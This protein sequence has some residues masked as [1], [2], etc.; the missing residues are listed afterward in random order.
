[1]T[2][3]GVGTGSQV[4][5][6]LHPTK[7]KGAAAGGPEPVTVVSGGNVEDGDEV[8]MDLHVSPPQCS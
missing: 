6:P 8:S 2:C 3:K 7:T 5:N 4:V 1:M